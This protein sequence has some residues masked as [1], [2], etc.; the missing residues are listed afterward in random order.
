M[1]LT[2]TYAWHGSGTVRPDNI[3]AGDGF[4]MQVGT[5]AAAAGVGLCREHAC[6]SVP[7]LLP[8]T[9]PSLSARRVPGL[10]A[11]G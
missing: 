7:G 2:Q 5:S 11:Q 3:A 9:P 1:E 4:M 8:R 10:L 6:L